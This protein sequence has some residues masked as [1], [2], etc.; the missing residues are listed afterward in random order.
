MTQGDQD[1][2]KNTT[3]YYRVFAV[4]KGGLSAGSNEVSGMPER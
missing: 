4:D 3:Y 1:L 2:R